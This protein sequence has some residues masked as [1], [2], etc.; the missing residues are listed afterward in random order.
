MDLRY[1]LSAVQLIQ[2]FTHFHIDSASSPCQAKGTGKA[3]SAGEVL[4]TVSMK[5]AI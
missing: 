5:G 4:I 1:K 2:Q 3:E